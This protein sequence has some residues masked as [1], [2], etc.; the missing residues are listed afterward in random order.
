MTRSFRAAV[1]AVV[2]FA[3]ALVVRSNEARASEELDVKSVLARPGV[4]L[5]AVEFYATWCEPCMKAMPRWKALKEKYYRQGL[6][7]VVVNTLD[8]NAGCRSIGWVPDETVCDLE[9]TVSENFQLKGQLPAAFLW[10]WQGNL[11][12][13]AGHIE[14]VEIAVEKYLGALWGRETRPR[15]QPFQGRFAQEKQEL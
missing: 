1:A 13:R 14:E 11:L 12:V 3:L 4:R 9:G 15:V 10:S 6:R 8:P 7:V 5:V 2:L